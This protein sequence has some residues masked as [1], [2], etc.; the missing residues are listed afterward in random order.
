MKNCIL[1]GTFRSD[2]AYRVMIE[3]IALIKSYRIDLLFLA[4][5]LVEK[6]IINSRQRAKLTDTLTGRS[7]DQRMD[8][9]LHTLTASIKVKGEVFDIFLEILSENDTI[10]CNQIARKLSDAY[11]QVLIDE[12]KNKIWAITIGSFS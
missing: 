6:K 10:L 3:N 7:Q 1:I 2:V 11:K 4:D 8:E 5:K 9:L 12:G